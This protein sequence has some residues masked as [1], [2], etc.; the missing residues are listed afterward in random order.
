MKR[1]SEILCK[2]YAQK[3]KNGMPT[4]VV[5]PSNVYGPHDKFDFERSHMFAALL[6][7]VVERQS[8]MVIWGTGSDVRDLIYV[9]DFVDGLMLAFEAV[10]DYLVVNIAAGETWSVKEVLDTMLKTDGFDGA[11]VNYDASKPQTTKM[12]KVDI[13]KAR[14]MLG[15]KAKVS[16]A[17]GIRRTAA[18]YR[19]N[20]A[21]GLGAH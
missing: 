18:W 9:D 19:K 10:K 16:L 20:P 5:R 15:F 17:E 6:R 13:S 11:V 4:V 12:R 21:Q 2:V 1:Y 3:I 7:R 8:P 14:S